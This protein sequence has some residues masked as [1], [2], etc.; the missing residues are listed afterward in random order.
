MF[1]LF[2][3]GYIFGFVGLLIAVPLAASVG[4]VLRFAFAQYYASPL[5]AAE[6]PRSPGES[7]Q[8]AASQRD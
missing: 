7:G 2:A 3:C 5:Y 4:V 8:R 1:S 6:M